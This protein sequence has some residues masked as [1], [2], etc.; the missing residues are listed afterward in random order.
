MTKFNVGLSDLSTISCLSFECGHCQRLQ[1]FPAAKALDRQNKADVGE[2]SRTSLTSAYSL[3]AP[4]RL[5]PN[6]L[7]I[8]Q[9]S[10]NFNRVVARKSAIPQ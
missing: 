6:W 5:R 3:E 8:I 9:S 10:D 2:A 4:I 1:R 7:L